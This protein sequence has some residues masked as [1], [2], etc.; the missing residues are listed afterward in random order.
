MTKNEEWKIYGNVHAAPGEVPDGWDYP[1]PGWR[2][3][4]E[5]PADPN[6]IATDP[7]PAQALP[8]GFHYL[9]SDR[10]K[11]TVSAAIRLRRPILVTGA[12]GTGKTTLADSIAYELGLG[13]VL[14]WLIT[15]KSTLREGLYE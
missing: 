10:I 8:D 11:N 14:T 9:A 3:F 1:A 2:K 13:P 7:P 6:L 5:L 4:G 15:S 12:P